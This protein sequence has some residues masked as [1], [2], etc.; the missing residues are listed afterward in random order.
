MNAQ[1]DPARRTSEISSSKDQAKLEA[2]INRISGVQ[3]LDAKTFKDAFEKKFGLTLVD[4]KVGENTS[5]VVIVE[6]GKE[7]SREL[8][9]ATKEGYPPLT[10][11]AARH[12]TLGF[13]VSV[14]DMSQ[15]TPPNIL[16]ILKLLTSMGM[17]KDIANIN[18]AGYEVTLFGPSQSGLQR[19]TISTADKRGEP[20]EELK[21]ENLL[22]V[23]SDE[24]IK[25]A[26]IKRLKG[27]SAKAKA[28]RTDPKRGFGSDAKILVEGLNQDQLAA[29]MPVL[30]ELLNS[31]EVNNLEA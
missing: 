15:V 4:F 8:I 11:E 17:L 9:Y 7:L 2:S 27:L 28:R 13:P 29:A 22:K 1:S 24:A 21:A 12:S 19:S 16:T 6:A 23:K 3:P 18:L 10:F 30:I 25:T 31:P 5:G 14:L 26:I 20:Y